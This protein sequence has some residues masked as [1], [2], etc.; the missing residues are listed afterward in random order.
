MAEGSGATLPIL[1]TIVS[2]LINLL[3]TILVRGLQKTG[4]DQTKKI[5]EL[6]ECIHKMEIVVSTI[7]AKTEA[8]DQSDGAQFHRHERRLDSLDARVNRLEARRRNGT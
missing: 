5:A 2:V 4:A 7:Q 3:L 8:H 1:L 6:S